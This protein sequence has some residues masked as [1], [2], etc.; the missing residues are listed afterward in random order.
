MAQMDVIS[1]TPLQHFRPTIPISSKLKPE[2]YV[3][4]G[5]III[6]KIIIIIKDNNNYNII[7]TNKVCKIVVH[8]F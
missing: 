6:R 8:S 4:F 5:L 1:I 2:I 3:H 7:I